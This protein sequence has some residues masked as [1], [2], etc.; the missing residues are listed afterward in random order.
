MTIRHGSLQRPLKVS[1]RSWD[2]YQAYMGQ[3]VKGELG[4]RTPVAISGSNDGIRVTGPDGVEAV[5]K[6]KRP[7]RLRF[8]QEVK[9][10]DKYSK[11]VK[12]GKREAAAEE[13]VFFFDVTVPF[14][15]ERKLDLETKLGIVRSKKT[16]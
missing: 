5:P 10:T 15:M 1:A 16:R 6:G 2:Q 8:V 4:G 9:A 12:G 14:P 7:T 11:L 13:H 3:F